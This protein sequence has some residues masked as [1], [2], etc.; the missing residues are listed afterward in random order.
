MPTSEGAKARIVA[1]LGR[2]K[3]KD[4]VVIKLTEGIICRSY[5]KILAIVNVVFAY[6]PRI[7]NV[8]CNYCNGR[9]EQNRSEDDTDYFFKGVFHYFL[10][11]CYYLL[12]VHQ[13]P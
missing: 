6:V 11:L 10:Q 3:G 8:F 7:L 12:I 2:S 5:F 4:S 13:I 9:A 1:Y